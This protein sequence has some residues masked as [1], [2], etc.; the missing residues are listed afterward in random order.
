MF[1]LDSNKFFI[2]NRIKRVSQKF[3]GDEALVRSSMNNAIRGAICDEVKQ[4][5][6]PKKGEGGD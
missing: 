6:L 2:D 3:R 1:L 5:I 4:V